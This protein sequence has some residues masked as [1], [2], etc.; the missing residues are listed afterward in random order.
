MR[1]SLCADRCGWLSRLDYRKLIVVVFLLRVILASAYDIGTSFTN[2]DVL[3]PDGRFYSVKG[4]HIAL[5]LDG[6]DEASLTANLVPSDK[7]SQESL[8]GILY[9]DKG[10]FP[11]SK[12]EPNIFSY[13]IGLSYYFFGYHTIWI[14]ILNICLSIFSSYLL[15]LV[16]KKLF[17]DFTANLFLVIALFLPSQF[18]Y[19]I[20][21]SRDLM[22]MF[23]VSLILWGIYNMGDIWKKA[24]N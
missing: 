5:L 19:S 20:T 13:I 12:N 8:I 4:R 16:A 15:F 18:G 2:K 10:N 22:R 3:L 23:V 17:G 1:V 7:A 6:Y 21:F 11:S 24:K 9:K 14:R